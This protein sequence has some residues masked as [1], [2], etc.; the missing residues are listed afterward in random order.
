MK[1]SKIENQ[2]NIKPNQIKTF[3]HRLNLFFIKPIDF[4]WFLVYPKTD[5]IKPTITP[6][7]GRNSFRIIIFLMKIE[8]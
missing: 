8:A 5:K 6:T 4:V 1:I 2:T 7:C 3:G